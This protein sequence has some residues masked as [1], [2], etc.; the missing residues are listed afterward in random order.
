MVEQI[1]NPNYDITGNAPMIPR[2]EVIAI[3][4]ELQ[5]L[6]TRCLILLSKYEP[7]HFKEAQTKPD[8]L[9]PPSWSQSGTGLSEQSLVR[10]IT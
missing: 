6:Q 8:Q 3:L 5:M 1:E 7:E 10:T 2:S 4:N 9:T